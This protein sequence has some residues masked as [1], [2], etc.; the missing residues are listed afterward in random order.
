MKQVQGVVF[1]GVELVE[2]LWS[3]HNFLEMVEGNVK[4]AWSKSSIGASGDSCSKFPLVYI[5]CY[6]TVITCKLITQ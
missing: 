6:S 2:Q 3:P 4:V 5:Q 1:N